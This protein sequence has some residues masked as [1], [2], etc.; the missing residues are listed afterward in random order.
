[1]LTRAAASL[2][3]V[4]CVLPTRAPF[5]IPTTPFSSGHGLRTLIGTD[6]CLP[7]ALDDNDAVTL[8]RSFLNGPRDWACSAS[9]LLFRSTASIRSAAIPRAIQTR[10][11]AAIRP[12]V[13]RV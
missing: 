13:L 1:M 2:L 11:A 4:L 5:A 9:A 7:S 3:V 8:D 10:L 12:I 6:T